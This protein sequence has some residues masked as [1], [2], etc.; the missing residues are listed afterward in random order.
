[1]SAGEI[2]AW[3]AGILAAIVLIGNAAKAVAAGIK[4]IRAPNDR[5]DGRLGKLESRLDKVDGKL[6]LDRRRLDAI[7]GGNRATQR[8]L[9][10]LLEHGLHGNNITQ[11]QAAKEGLE[12][13]LINR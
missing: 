13:H 4:Q 1:M 8:A 11:M 12:Q 2:W 6:D 7:E 3:V 9:L 10:A 5:Q